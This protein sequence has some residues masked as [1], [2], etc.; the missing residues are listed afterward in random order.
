M[1]MYLF[2]TIAWKRV[3]KKRPSASRYISKSLSKTESK[4]KKKKVHSDSYLAC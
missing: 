1:G 2:S 4:K 3:G